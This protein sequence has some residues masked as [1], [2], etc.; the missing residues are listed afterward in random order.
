MT[1]NI[2]HY[3]T[4]CKLFFGTCDDT[5]DV[6]VNAWLSEHPHVDIISMQHQQARFGDHSIF[7]MYREVK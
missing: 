4:K 1:S 2:D 7:V 3:V 5:A 6:K